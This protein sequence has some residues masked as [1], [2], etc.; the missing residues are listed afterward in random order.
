MARS[1][2]VA[3]TRIKQL[4]SRLPLSPTETLEELGARDVMN[5]CVELSVWKIPANASE[6]SRYFVA[7]FG[8]SLGLPG[9]F[10]GFLIH[11]IHERSAVL[12]IPGPSQSCARIH[13]VIGGNN[14]GSGRLITPQLTAVLLA[15]RTFCCGSRSIS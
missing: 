3:I 15:P 8:N 4:T 14:A 9:G 2:D 7:Y 6:S 5:E 11:S 10:D 1:V 12:A 13:L